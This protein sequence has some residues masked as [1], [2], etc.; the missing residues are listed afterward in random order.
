M[1]R[2]VLE[3]IAVDPGVHFGQPVVKGTRIPVYAVLELLR[4][5]RTFEAIQHDYYT[6]LAREDIQACLDYA[7]C[8]IREEEVHLSHA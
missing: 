5:G 8:L 7:A 3:R 4:D 6:D 2:A 1:T